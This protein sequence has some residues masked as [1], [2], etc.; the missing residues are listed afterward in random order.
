MQTIVYG[1]GHSIVKVYPVMSL[2]VILLEKD[3]MLFGQGIEI[4][5]FS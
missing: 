1:H 4:F 5:N 2:V 3:C